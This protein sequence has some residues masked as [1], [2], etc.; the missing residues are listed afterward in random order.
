[1]INSSTSFVIPTKNR[2]SDLIKTIKSINKQNIL[3]KELLIIDQS[4]NNNE[5]RI[6]S[7]LKTSIKLKYFHQVTIKGLTQAK[8]YAL[9]KASGDII[10]F[11][12][13]DIIL[14]K[15]FIINILKVLSYEKNLR[16]VCGTLINVK[17]TIFKKILKFIFY[18]GLFNDPRL[19][20][21]NNL[22]SDKVILSDKISGGISA[23]KKE[24]FIKNKFDSKNK[25][26]LF[27]DI[28][29]SVRVNKLWKNSTAIVI[30]SQVEHKRS[31]INRNKD[32]KLLKMKIRESYIFYNK[33]SRNLLKI[34]YLLYKYSL[35]FFSVFQ[36]F[37][38]FDIKYLITFF[39]EIKLLSKK[40]YEV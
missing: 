10:F 24:V 22:K 26:H 1:M 13:D 2:I 18:H 34:D 40:N 21:W 5:L 23:W 29:F 14:S 25:L 35:F 31:R 11:L 19:K 6:R 12:E 28:D 38:N 37:K 15:N 39:T 3:P 32:I 16:G 8:N 33:N 17:I 20:Q 27:E 30:S 7:A 4:F 9:R 36:T